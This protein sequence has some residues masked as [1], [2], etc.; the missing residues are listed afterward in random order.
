MLDFE[1]SRAVS[2]FCKRV[3]AAR[4]KHP[5]LAMPQQLFGMVVSTV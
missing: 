1:L 3:V 4:A 5:I 2:P